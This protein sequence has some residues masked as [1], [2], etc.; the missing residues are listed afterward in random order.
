VSCGCNVCVDEA[1]VRKPVSLH[2]QTVRDSQGR[3]RFHG[4]FTGG[5]SAGYY[6]T[7]GSEAGQCI[8]STRFWP[9]LLRRLL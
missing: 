4:A 8:D 2:D 6:N 5:F 3:L 9:D 7:V 1:P